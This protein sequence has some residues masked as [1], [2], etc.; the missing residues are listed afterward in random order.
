MTATVSKTVK[1]ANTHYYK[2][3]SL[4]EKKGNKKDV[5]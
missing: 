4:I 3:T 5:Q 1:D 2:T